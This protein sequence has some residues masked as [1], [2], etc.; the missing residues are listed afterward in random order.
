MVS[1]MKS[2]QLDNAVKK[3]DWILSK[4]KLLQSDQCKEYWW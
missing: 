2:F 4:S 1:A 3:G